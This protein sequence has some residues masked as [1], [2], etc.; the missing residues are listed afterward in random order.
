[1]FL[2]SP[3]FQASLP[4]W[5]PLGLLQSLFLLP[6]PPSPPTPSPLWEGDSLDQGNRCPVLV[7]DATWS[8]C[9]CGVGFPCTCRGPSALRSP[10]LYRGGWTGS[11]VGSADQDLQQ[12]GPLSC[13]WKQGRCGWAGK[14]VIAP[15]SD[16]SCRGPRTSLYLWRHR[17][18]ESWEL[19]EG[20]R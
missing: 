7:T 8:K 1:M 6:G 16:R 3:T 2:L 9:F 17:G 13:S 5:R 10:H 19:S 4:A 20:P 12:L 15:R 11:T 14:S 18:R